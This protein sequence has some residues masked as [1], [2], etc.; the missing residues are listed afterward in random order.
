MREKILINI[1]LIILLAVSILLVSNA[2]KSILPDEFEEKTFDLS[3][4]DQQACDL[5]TQD[6][7]VKDASGATIDSNFVRV[8]LSSFK[9]IIDSTTLVNNTHNQI[10][11]DG[12][13]QL[14]ID[15]ESI[16]PQKLLVM[17]RDLSVIPGSDGADTCYAKLNIA[18]SNCSEF[19]FYTSWNFGDDEGF[20]GFTEDNYKGY[21]DFDIINNDS[22]YVSMVSERPLA[23]IS[24]CTQDVPLSTGDSLATSVIKGR[25]IYNLAQGDYIIRS[26]ISS[27]NIHAFKLLIMAAE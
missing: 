19:V 12:F 5:L 1:I 8:D 11:V 23:S 14:L 20:T 26:T 3:D 18:G 13:N 21:I 9:N 17:Q 25:Q 7:Y 6:L 27:I 22:S 16:E 2:C 24:G 4:F 15:L 10:I